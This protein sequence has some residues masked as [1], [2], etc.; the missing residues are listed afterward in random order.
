MASEASK[1]TVRWK[2]IGVRHFLA[3]AQCSI[4]IEAKKFLDLDIELEDPEALR[5]LPGAEKLA[6]KN[7]SAKLEKWVPFHTVL[8]PHN[9]FVVEHIYHARQKTWSFYQRFVLN[10][11]FRAHCKPGVFKAQLP[12]LSKKSFWHAPLR[13]FETNSS[14]HKALREFR[15]EGNALQTSAFLIIPERIVKD[16][17]ENLIINLLR[18]TQRLIRLAKKLWPI[19]ICKTSST[20]EKYESIKQAMEDVHG[21]GPTWVKMLM[22]EVDIAMPKIGLL[23][24]RCEVGSGALDPLKNILKEE[25]VPMP[26]TGN[27][28]DGLIALRDH[29]VRG[30]CDSNHKHFKKVI[31]KFER[32]ARQHFKKF[33]LLVKQMQM[34]DRP[35]GCSTLQVQLCEFRQLQVLMQRR[36]K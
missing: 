21:C 29:I 9:K 14:M 18:R 11:V 5:M 31:S 33:P 2:G 4:K 25:G 8:G 32:K 28:S 23:H 34:A 24:D 15:A 7:S 35:L 6:Q 19:M 30:S 27:R 3:Y 26:Q 20:T 36:K 17:D 16:D 10:L 22:V 13:A 12:I 1:K